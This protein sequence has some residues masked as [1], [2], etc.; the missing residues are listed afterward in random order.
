[1][2]LNLKYNNLLDIINLK[3]KVYYPLHEFVS[4]MPQGYDTPIGD[5]GV[6]LSGGQRQ[7]INIAQVFLKNPEIMILDEAT[8][9]L[10]SR[11]EKKIQDAI[12][13][14]SKETTLIVHS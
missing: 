10:D 3:Y 8:S 11:S 13:S 2:R 9:A 1:M 5:R 12:D 14:V 4:K 6:M 7:R